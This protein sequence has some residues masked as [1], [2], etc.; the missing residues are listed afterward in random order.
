MR[1]RLA[2]IS[3]LLLATQAF[4]SGKQWS[5]ARNMGFAGP[6]R[7]VTTTRQRFMQEPIQPDGPTL[8]YPMFCE[9]CEFDRS[10]AQVG[11]RTGNDWQRKILDAQGRVAEEVTENEKGEVTWR[12]VFTNGPFGKVRSETYDNGKLTSA[13]TFDYDSQGNMIESATYKGDGTLESRT[14]SRFDARGNEIEQAS[15]GPGDLYSDVIMTYTERTGELASFTRLNRD[16]SLRLS[17]TTDGRTV[18]SYWQQPGDQRTYGS[19]VCLGDDEGTERDCRQ[20]NSDGS[21]ASTHYEFA[22]M[23]KRNP[24][25]VVLRDPDQQRLMEADYE[26]AFDEYGNWTSRTVWVWTRKSGER[27]LLEKDARTLTYYPAK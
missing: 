22:G 25:K 23:S 19:D 20:Y 17:F 12:N 24:V 7:S 5:D 26:Y 21:Y 13:A 1:R 4:G 15:E 2:A 8:V 16:G 10:G 11:S 6:V 9:Y 3:W 14:W 18:L 27:R